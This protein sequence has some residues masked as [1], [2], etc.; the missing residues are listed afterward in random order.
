MTDAFGL[1]GTITSSLRCPTRLRGLIYLIVVVVQSMS[2]SLEP[3]AMISVRTCESSAKA[4]L[5]NCY[6][7]LVEHWSTAELTLTCDVTPSQ[8][9]HRNLLALTCCSVIAVNT[10]QLSQTLPPTTWLVVN[11]N[12]DLKPAY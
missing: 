9:Y 11:L 10:Q 7:I 8:Q 6:A 1:H 4:C 3:I 12:N 5:R 2:A